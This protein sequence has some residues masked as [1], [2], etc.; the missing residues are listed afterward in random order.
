MVMEGDVTWVVNTQD[1][2]QVMD[3]RIV[4]VKPI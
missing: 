3:Y 1:D 2:I 4:Q